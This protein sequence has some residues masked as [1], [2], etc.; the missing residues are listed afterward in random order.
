[1]GESSTHWTAQ[2]LRDPLRAS[3]G[4]PNSTQQVVYLL[5][6]RVGII[7]EKPGINFTC[8]TAFKLIFLNAVKRPCGL[9]ATDV[10]LW[11]RGPE[12]SEA[13]ASRASAPGWCAR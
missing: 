9:A 1:M 2:K 13:S 6:R 8:L 5:R 7:V 12:G 11:R 10:R 4:C 3:K